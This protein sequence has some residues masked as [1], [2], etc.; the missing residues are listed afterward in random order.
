MNSWEAFRTQF[1]GAYGDPDIAHTA[2]I[3]IRKITQTGSVSNYAANFLELASYLSYPPAVLKD[4]FE[5]GLKEEM[6]KLIAMQ[7]PAQVPTDFEAFRT[8]VIMMDTR[9]NKEEYVR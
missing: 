9:C 8:W 2:A 4:Q 6:K 1:V 5:Y 7:P 3:K